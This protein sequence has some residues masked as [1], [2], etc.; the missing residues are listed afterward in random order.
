MSEE[1][2]SISEACAEE[3]VPLHMMISWM[4]RSGALLVIPGTEDSRCILVSGDEYHAPEC[5]CRFL[6]A[7][8]DVQS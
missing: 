8:P 3:G 4:N 6:T 1:R 7:H 2:V 5:E